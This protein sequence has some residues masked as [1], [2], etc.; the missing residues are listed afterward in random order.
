MKTKDYLR[1]VVEEIHTTV[2]ATVD[3][4]NRPFTAAIDMMDYDE[5]GFYFLTAKG[6]AFYDR[7]SNSPY[8]AFTAMKGEDTMSTV[9]V[10]IQGQVKELGPE[11]LPRLFEKNPYMNDIYTTEE[12]KKALTVFKIFKGTGEWFD[13]SKLP[14]ERALFSF[15]GDKVR[16]DGYQVTEACIGCGICASI[17]PQGAVT[18]VEGTAKIDTTTCIQCGVCAEECPSKAIHRH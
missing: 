10:S 8:V 5:G 17:C 16:E 12:S 9:A 18:L 7:L 14:I 1:Y 6:K 3:E 4:N 15:G 13:L 2:M 11:L